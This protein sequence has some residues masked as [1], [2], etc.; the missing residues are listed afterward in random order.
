MRHGPRYALRAELLRLA[1][2]EQAATFDAMVSE[3][4]SQAEAQPKVSTVVDRLREIR[5]A[6]ATVANHL[7][8]LIEQLAEDAVRMLEAAQPDK[9]DFGLD[10]FLEDGKGQVS[11]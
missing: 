8:G 10:E 5:L 4:F 6:N 11:H 1:G 3:S 7:E 9:Y 2:H